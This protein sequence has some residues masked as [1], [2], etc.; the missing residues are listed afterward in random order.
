[1]GCCAVGP[2]VKIDGDY[3]GHISTNKV[4]SLLTKF[5]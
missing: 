2:A 1:M 3:Y 5:E 4:N